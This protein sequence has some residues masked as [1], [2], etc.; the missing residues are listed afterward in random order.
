MK[1]EIKKTVVRCLKCKKQVKDED[2]WTLDKCK[3]CNGSIWQLN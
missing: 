2:L 3:K 1:K